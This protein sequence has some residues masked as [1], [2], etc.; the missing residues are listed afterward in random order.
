MSNSG[1]LNLPKLNKVSLENFSLYTLQP[2]IEVIFDKQL[3]CLA[4]ANGLGKST[5]LT[6]LNF[7]LTGI[8]PEP[9]RP[10]K[11][12][13]EY[14]EHC[15]YFSQNYF[16]GRIKPTEVEIAQ[17]TIDFDVNQT[18]FI[19]T[20][21]M[22]EPKE[23]RE[24][25]ITNI[26]TGEV[27]IIRT[28][29]FEKQKFYE[30]ALS[31]AIGLKKFVEYV[32]LQN[33]LFTF[34]EKRNLIFWTPKVLDQLSFLAFSI[35]SNIA[36]ESVTIRR[37]MEKWESRAKNNKWQAT[38]ILNRINE[39]K[40]ILSAQESTEESDFDEIAIK[41]EYD[42]LHENIDQQEIRVSHLETSLKDTSVQLSNA[43]SKEIFL[44]NRYNE[45]FNNRIESSRDVGNHPLI[46]QA[47]NDLKCPICGSVHVSSIDHIKNAIAAG[48]CPLCFDSVSK[49]NSDVELAKFE[50]LKEL[51]IQIGKIRNELEGILNEHNRISKDIE[52]ESEKLKNYNKTLSKFEDKNKEL[53]AQIKSN[54]SVSVNNTVIDRL[55]QQYNEFNDK[56]IAEYKK[57]DEKKAELQILQKKI[58][59]KYLEVQEEFIPLYKSLAQSFLGME[60]DIRMETETKERSLI[61]VFELQGTNRR[62][63]YQ[64]SESQRFFID[65]ALR[66]ALASFISKE[67]NNS[68]LFI[69]TPEGSLDIAYE[70]K[71]GEMI[72]KFIEHKNHVIMTANINSSKL[73]IEIAKN[74]KNEKMHLHRMTTWT[75]LT[76]VQVLASDDFRLAYEAIEKEMV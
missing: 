70:K 27:E 24:L 30:E 67:P 12:P 11:S 9:D 34:D 5:F 4:G 58:K 20:R 19:I 45:I 35:D 47:L 65:I 1:K 55:T 44:R 59:Q 21:G 6:A 49:P 39:F 8:V 18:N 41:E 46:K 72:S 43:N 37:D 68:T 61:F 28:S 3:F 23:L 16:R 56:K 31:K 22:F 13:E 32:F 2:T 53:L 33:F 52:V 63:F 76:D 10:F 75:N 54:E 17:V 73:L 15:I 74:C 42:Q 26:D 57:R 29:S 62:E 40:R 66:M 25:V 36:D 38:Q 64:L 71:A 14:Y 48:L 60:L 51:D 50:E 7:G 69:D